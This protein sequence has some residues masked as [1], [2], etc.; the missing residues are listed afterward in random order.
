Q[1]CSNCHGDKRL[2]E[3][4][5]K[6]AKAEGRK[7]GEKYP[8]A[9]E[10]YNESFHGKVT[11]FGYKKAANCLDCHADYDN[12]YLSVHFIRPSRDPASPVSPER[13]LKTCQ[14]CHIYADKN[15][16]AL[17]PHPT[18]Y[19]A[20]DPFRHYAEIVYGWVGDVV[21]FLLIGMALVETIGRRRDGVIWKI[22]KG[23][24]WWRPSRRG[25]NRK[26]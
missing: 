2:V 6:A 1:L 15:Y 10:S 8:Y 4:H 5:M 22:K 7:L 11:R 16:A 3:R 17:D 14:R 23:S 13:K 24:S 19:K 25:R 12:Y 9:V 26:V 18:N 20:D 21:L